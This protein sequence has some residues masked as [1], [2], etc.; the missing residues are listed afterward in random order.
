MAKVLGIHR[1]TLLRIRRNP[2]SPFVEGR[3]FRWSGLTT[4]SNLQ[5]NVVK[6][7]STFTK[8]RRVPASEL[9]T[10]GEALR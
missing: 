1:Q 2:S 6:A 9:E 7:E 8:A 4:N 5:W 3:D 10:Y